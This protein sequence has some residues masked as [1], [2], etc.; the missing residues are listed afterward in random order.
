[1]KLKFLTLLSQESIDYTTLLKE[2]VGNKKVRWYHTLYFIK[3]FKKLIGEIEVLRN[4]DPKK[5]EESELCKIKRPD[6]IDQLPYSA[7]IELQTLFQNP[8]EKEI[9][10][11]IIECISL[12]CF[13]SHTKTKEFDSDTKEFSDFKK[14]ISNE[15]LVQMLGLYNWIDKTITS[16]TEK[17]NSLFNQVRVHDQD[18]DNVGGDGLMSKFDVLNTIKKTCIAFNLDYYKV[19]QMPYGLVQANSLSEA[20]KSYI[21]DKMRIA[22]ES[23]MKSKRDAG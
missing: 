12:C 18:W 14:L 6:S 9:G 8:G 4:L 20:T 13:I 19:L 21:Q 10:E 5:V 17:W 2:E 15:D 11:L 23:R 16:S 22:I 3:S 1:M 7:F